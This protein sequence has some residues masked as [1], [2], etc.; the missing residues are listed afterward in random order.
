MSE[1]QNKTA[2]AGLLAVQRDLKAPKNQFNKFG[3]YN[4][5]SCEDI[6]QA[7]RPLCNENG[8]DLLLSDEPAMVG[9]RFY[10]KAT[11][12]VMD[13]ATGETIST[14]AYAREADAKKGMD[15]A[16]VTGASSSYA[17]KYAL[18]GLF[19]IDDTKDMD[20]DEHARQTGAQTARTSNADDDHHKIVSKLAEMVKQSGIQPS[21]MTAIIKKHY[22]KSGTKEMSTKELFDLAEKLPQY[23]RE[24]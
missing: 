16:Q 20:T 14:T 9:A 1:E 6:L 15:P 2:L 5:R 18:C 21:Q 19:A 22:G 3:G 11:A 12:T 8:L 13:I 24:E 7:A 10:I 17:R 4:Y 23:L